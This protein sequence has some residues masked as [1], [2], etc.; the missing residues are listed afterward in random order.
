MQCTI[1]EKQTIK[2]THY[3]ETKKKI[4]DSQRVRVRKPQV[5]QQWAQSKHASG[6]YRK[7][8]VLRQ[9]RH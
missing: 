4:H 5:E 6:T 8:K 2:L 9:G 1:R 7:I 3:D